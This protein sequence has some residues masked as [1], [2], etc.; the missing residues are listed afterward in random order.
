[1]GAPGRS[2]QAGDLGDSLVTG[3]DVS[4]DSARGLMARLGHHR[5]QRDLLVAEVGCSGVTELVEVQAAGVLLEQDPGAVVAQA[6]PAGVRA[7]VAGRGL[8]GGDGPAGG[9]EQRAAGA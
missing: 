9:Q 3:L 2:E 8:A 4:H 5:L 7:D 6:P 1:V